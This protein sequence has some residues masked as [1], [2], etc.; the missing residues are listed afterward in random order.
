MGEIQINF[1]ALS[2]G[3][4]GIGKT[5]GQLQAT[6]DE[7]EAD[8][9][10]MIETWSGAAQEAY[11]TCKNRWDAAALELAAVLQTVSR[12]VGIANENYQATHSATMQIW[13]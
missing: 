1:Q 8:L 5:F 4:A 3:Q 10:P 7:L 9:Q 11:L 6:L 12:A 13:T 2:A